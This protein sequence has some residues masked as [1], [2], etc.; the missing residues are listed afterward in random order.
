MKK[1]F[2]F[3]LHSIVYKYLL[4]NKRE[5]SSRIDSFSFYGFCL[6]YIRISHLVIYI[7]SVIFIIIFIVYIVSA[8]TVIFII[9]SLETKIVFG[10]YFL[11][12]V[13]QMN[14]W[15]QKINLGNAYIHFFIL[16]VTIYPIA[17]CKKYTTMPIH[18]CFGSKYI[19]LLR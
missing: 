1:N 18:I 7:Q 16:V 10:T 5:K 12:N 4:L 3:Y 8:E 6:I 2:I 14:E 13:C 17:Y 11:I 19:L 15:I 9:V